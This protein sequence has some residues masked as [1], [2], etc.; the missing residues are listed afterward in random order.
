MIELNE[1]N[2]KRLEGIRDIVRK[3]WDPE[4]VRPYLMGYPPHGPEHC[5][6]VEEK[7]NQLLPDETS[8]K[9]KEDERFLLLASV[10]LHDI[11]MH[12]ELR[13]VFP[14]D[15]R[16]EEGDD[17]LRKWEKDTLR[18]THADRSATFIKTKASE[19]GLSSRERDLLAAICKYHRKSANLH[20]VRLDDRH[21]LLIA[22]LRLAD[23]LHIPERAPSGELK[24]YI[25][26][27]MDA[28]SKFHWFKSLYTSDIKVLPDD[29]IVITL[30][31]PDV[32]KG[33]L[34]EDVKPL[35]A[36][37]KTELEDELDSVKYFLLKSRLDNKLELPAYLTVECDP[38]RDIEGI[39]MLPEEIR[40]FRQL[41]GIIKLFDPTQSPNSGSII[42]T[43]LTQIV[44]LLNPSDTRNSVIDLTEF[45]KSILKPLTDARPCHVCLRKV[46]REISE[47]L[48]RTV[49][50]DEKVANIAEYITT[51]KA[52]RV[53][54]RKGLQE[55]AKPYLEKASS[56][57]LYGYSDT[58]VWCL[59][60]L[61]EKKKDLEI[62]VCECSTKAKHRYNN[63]LIYNDG[64]KTI[65]KLK[66][67]GIDIS[68]IHYIPDASISNLFSLKTKN[69]ERIIVLFGTNGIEEKDFED[70]EGTIKVEKWSVAHALGHLAI[71]DIAKEYNVPVYVVA[72][73]MKIGEFPPNPENLRDDPWYSTDI[74]IDNNNQEFRWE[75]INKYN[76]RE[77]IVPPGKIDMIITEQD[78][79]LP[80]QK[81]KLSQIPKNKDAPEVI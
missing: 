44:E 12:P 25:Q 68:K 78:I 79:L 50:D 4:K 28:K 19:L 55:K 64:I 24:K 62:Y 52:E 81:K 35:I 57:L 2:R 56:I 14:K 46:C 10:W 17:V 60:A 58:I 41:L 40:D 77:D 13:D 71:A 49:S 29:K 30:K 27:G 18:P 39:P 54:S 75:E 47:Q 65:K 48:N 22:Y 21:R 61:G 45:I 43:V 74:S 37:L 23:A 16:A 11:G 15:P 8:K 63:R 36:V 33:N 34:K 59:D 70:K 7:L 72:E 1:T 73:S 3:I 5:K 20:K 9:L 66:E 38:D 26:Y 67:M 51:C 31:T 6:K 53:K 69:N 76:P 42:D 32:W 80:K